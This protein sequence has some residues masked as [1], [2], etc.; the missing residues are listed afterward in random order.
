M[1]AGDILRILQCDWFRERE[2]ITMLLAQYTIPPGWEHN[3]TF[4][5]RII[6]SRLE[7]RKRNVHYQPYLLEGRSKR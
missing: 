3:L 7:R 2:E 4:I 5:F 1:R 6:K